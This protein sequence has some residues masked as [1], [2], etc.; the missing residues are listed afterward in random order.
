MKSL[1]LSKVIEYVGAEWFQGP[2]DFKVR[3]IITKPGTLRQGTVF[4]NLD[5]HSL[6][7]L[8]I[9]KSY[10]NSAV[11]TSVTPKSGQLGEGITLIKVPNVERAFW[12][13]V[14]YYR[15]LFTVP[16]IGVTGTNGKT[17][18][19]EMIKHILSE[20][21]RLNS[22]YRSKNSL[23]SN[24]KYLL[25]MDERIDAGVFEMPVYCPGSLLKACRFLR[26]QVGIITNIGVDHI[27]GCR[28]LNSYIK[29]KAE[30]LEGVGDN[31]TIILN[32]DDKNIGRIDLSKFK[33]KII[34]FGFSEKSDFRALSVAYTDNG[35]EFTFLYDKRDY[36]AFIP[37]FGEFNVLNA[38]AAIAAVRS[39]GIEVQYAIDRLASF[40]NI[41][42]HF[43]IHMGINGSVV[44]DDTWNTNPSSS[45][46]ALKLFKQ[47][48]KGK[49]TIAALGRMTL[50]A[51]Y[52]DKYHIKIGEK[53]VQLGIDKLITMDNESKMIG[54]GAI[55]AGMDPEK[56][57]F[58]NGKGEVYTVLKEILNPNSIVLLKATLE[59]SYRD[60][61]DK[62]T[63]KE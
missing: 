28:T 50:L 49:E 63:V 5:N 22:T 13:F 61:I 38:V 21:Y 4:F 1:D 24:L 23:S 31:G 45:E 16:V 44:I 19:K 15:G 17:T 7:G 58:C 59:D 32:S 57:Y 43:E 35:T 33:G 12:K 30:F 60:L 2:N 52:A 51:E 37:A 46:A 10:P 47:L 6:E 9:N 56:V 27:E 48:S 39:I 34:Y 25:R 40:K 54:Q 11:V 20:K 36:K 41:E 29:A 8:K 42:G 26:P 62:I 18:T 3:H 55:K 14:D 53:T